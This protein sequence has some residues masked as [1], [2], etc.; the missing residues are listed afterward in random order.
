MEKRSR[1]CLLAYPSEV[2]EIDGQISDVSYV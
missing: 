2:S 1:V